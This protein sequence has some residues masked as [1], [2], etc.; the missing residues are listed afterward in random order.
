M[1]RSVGEGIQALLSRVEP[2]ESELEKRRSHRRTIEQGLKS[3]FS[4]F[5][6]VQ[7]IGSHTRATAIHVWSDVDYFAMLGAPDIMWGGGRVDSRTTLKKTKAGLEA[8]FTGTDI[9][10]DGPAVVVGFG[11]GGGAVDVVPGVWAGMTASSP[12]Y[13]VYLIPDGAGGWAQTSPQPPN[14]S[15]TR[16]SA[17][18]AS[19]RARFGC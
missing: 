3:S 1:A 4:G 7:V 13:P 12:Q 15:A 10:I 14:T 11:G 17:R 9:W 5:N 19:S 6:Q 8:R 16:I 2:L 18:G